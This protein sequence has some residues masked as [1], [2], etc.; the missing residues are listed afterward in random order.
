[1]PN[2]NIK[3]DFAYEDNYNNIY[4]AN[5]ST[6][7]N[8]GNYHYIKDGSFEKGNDGFI[9]QINGCLYESYS[10]PGTLTV[11]TFNESGQL[12]L[13]TNR[14]TII[15]DYYFLNGEKIVAMDC[16]KAMVG[17]SGY[18]WT[19]EY[20]TWGI[21]Q[22]FSESYFFND[23]FI[24]GISMNES[25]NPV[26]EYFDIR[27]LCDPTYGLSVFTNKPTCSVSGILMEADNLEKNG[28]ILSFTVDDILET[29]VYYIETTSNG[30][31]AVLQKN[32]DYEYRLITIQPIN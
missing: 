6:T 15:S 31:I 26:I 14:L 12:V 8:S 16:N 19:D 7:N 22:N 32:I 28:N 13:P 27:T 20:E 29:S 30:L 9:Y 23:Y 25:F 2:K 21:L 4:I 18:G 3:V 17:Y 5:S 10:Y 1:M 11:K 24:V